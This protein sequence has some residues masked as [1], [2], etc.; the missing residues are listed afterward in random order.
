MADLLSTPVGNSDYLRALQQNTDP[1]AQTPSSL[2]AMGQDDFLLL[3]TTQL[4]NQDPSKPMDA[5]DFVTDLTQMSQLEATN[6]MNA[7]IVAMT[8]SFNNL[9]TMQGASLIGR[10]VQIE[11][12]KFSYSSERP[13]QFSLKTDEPFID[14]T[15]VISDEDGIVKELSY[16]DFL[17]DSEK[18]SWDGLASKPIEWNGIDDVGAARSDGVYSITAYGTDSTGESQSIGTV[19]GSRVNT[20]GINPDGTMTLT[21]ATG[22]KVGMDTVREISG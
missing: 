18:A 1:S 11:G 20:V 7:S 10:N 19:V 13:S 12:D 17:S 5:T 15:V 3:L 2:S 9:Q 4:Q 22:E 16:L 14:I 8:A 6:S 21:L